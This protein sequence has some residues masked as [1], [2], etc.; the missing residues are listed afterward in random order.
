MGKQTSLARIAEA[1]REAAS[2]VV[3]SHFNPDADAYGSMCALALGLRSLGKKVCL[4]N[5]S[6]ALQRYAFVPL[7][8]EIETAFPPGDWDVLAACDCGDAGRVGDKLK[9]ELKRFPLVINLDHHVSNDF[10]GHLNHVSPEGS[11]ASEIIFN[12]LK[13]LKVKLSPEMAECLYA[14]IVTDTGGFRYSSTAASTLR[15]AADLIK[16]GVELARVCTELYGR[17]PAGAVKLRAESVLNHRTYF[18]GKMALGVVTKEMLMRYGCTEDDIDRIVESL[19]DIEGVEVSVVVSERDDYWK[20][21][22]RAKHEGYDVS[23]VA[24][25]HGGGGHTQASGFRWRGSFDELERALR[26]DFSGMLGSR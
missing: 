5:E 10:F 20:A 13:A 15:C 2:V 21:S 12:L 3:V 19:R 8:K 25:S 9:H 14:G 23:R 4:V 22:L 1:L 6:G 24:Q 11:S 7:V 17:E 18:E 16:A 26:A